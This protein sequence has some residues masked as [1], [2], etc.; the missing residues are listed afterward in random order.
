MPKPVW[1]G[2]VVQS[3]NSSSDPDGDVL[4]YVWEVIQP[5]GSVNTFSI[6]N[7]SYH[8]L[9]PGVY[10]VILTVSDGRLSNSMVKLIT[11]MPLT[12]HSD[13]TYTSNW[14][15]IHEK[16]GHQ[17]AAAPK[18]F[19]SG[20]IFVVSSR[21]SLAPVDEVTAWIETTGLDGKSLYVL[22]RLQVSAGDP[23]LF[24]GELFDSR[25]QS[26]VEGI[27]SGLQTIHFQIRYRNG[28]VKQ[29]GVPI[30]IIG[31]VNKSVGVHRV[32]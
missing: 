30:N 10:K 24:V 21:S 14:L 20:E 32:H 9:T 13:V 15:L 18:D 4:N 11:A 27:P 8:F 28:V 31:N 22:D 19:Y 29:E 2:D 25:F 12:I 5:N 26:F 17:T 1:E 23:T 6:Q 16:S 3:V 7:F